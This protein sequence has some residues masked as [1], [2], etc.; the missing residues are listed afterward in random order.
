[1]AL[2]FKLIFRILIY[3]PILVSAAMLPPLLIAFFL[4]EETEIVAFGIPAMLFLLCGGLLLFHMSKQAVLFRRGEQG[5]NM[6]IREK[7]F[8]VAAIWIFIS[9]AGSLPYWISGA[10]PQFGSAL[11]ESTSGFTAT[12]ATIFKDVESLPESILFWR[13]FSN[14]LG[15]LGIL[16]LAIAFFPSLGLNGYTI[17]N[18]EMVSGDLQQSNAKINR[19][20]TFL[21]LI[22]L[23]FTLAEAGLLKIGGMSFRDAFLCSMSTVST[24]GFTPYND[25]IGHFN[26]L[27]SELVIAFFMILAGTN[28][29]LYYKMHEKRKHVLIR[30][31][32]FRTY[33]GLI[34]G[35]VIFITACL[36]I[37][38]NSSE[39]VAVRSAFF[40]VV[41][42]LT[43]TG[44]VTADF[45]L[46]PT[47]C[48]MFLFMLSFIGGCSASTA[49][50]I[51]IIRVIMLFQ[52]IRIGIY[53][54]LHT[55]VVTSVKFGQ[56]KL[57]PDIASNISNFYFS[58]FLV[59]LLGTFLLSL[60]C[61][62]L[63]TAASASASCLANNG[64][65]LGLI[66]GDFSYALF[67]E[68]LK[69]YLAFQMIAGRLETVVIL[70]LF[71]PSF[72]RI[73]H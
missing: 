50:G 32:E 18:S 14:W 62:D 2:N 21:A 61:P 30:N 72:W 73:S 71:L 48:C 70:L 27:Y 65:G 52:I 3:M 19:P 59:F 49:G 4:K 25:N 22:Y 9:L 1:M 47:P 67:S 11:F 40:Q 60:D 29:T 45:S 7:I 39:G 54:K 20:A 24:G 8:T 12:G 6:G 5:E 57:S 66:S 53:K 13:S 55:S 16:L 34:A 33:L 15:G 10:A 31:A 46:W 35:S 41:S 28:F 26:S 51:K 37:L 44:F 68:P 64:L 23:I 43:T 42:V 56:Q 69:I 58:Y 36:M 63:I 38:C 17:A